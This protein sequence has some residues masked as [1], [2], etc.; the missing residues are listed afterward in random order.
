MNSWYS[1]FDKWRL[2]GIQ[3]SGHEQYS[4]FRTQSSDQAGSIMTKTTC[5]YCGVGCGVDISVKHKAHGTSVQVTGDVDHP[6]NF[7]RLCI[8][9][10]NLADTLGLESRV[11]QPMFGRKTSVKSQ[12]GIKPLQKL[13]ISSKPVSMSMDVKVSLFMFQVSC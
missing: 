4:T 6:S 8:K 12:H 1:S 11:L 9:G 13:Q 10:S 7:G 5:P 3:R 2:G